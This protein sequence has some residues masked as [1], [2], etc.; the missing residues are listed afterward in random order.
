M[1]GL[2]PHTQKIIESV[3]RL[4]CI[5][6]YTLVGGTALSLQLG[7]RQSEDLDFMK[8]RTSKNEKIEVAW[9]QIEKELSQI[10]KIQHKDLLDIDH[11]EYLVSDVKLSFYACD[12]HSPVTHPIA[13]Q[14]N[15][16]LADII[17][18]G[19]M[20]IEVMLRRSNFRD[21]YDIYSIL[22]NNV[23]IQELITLATSYSGHKLKTKNIMAILTNSKRFIRDAHF[24]QLQPSY[25]ISPQEI[26][27]YIKFCL[28]NK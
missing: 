19:A 4:E 17:S 12:K 21:Y 28:S 15:I 24:E 2:A 7:T 8:W 13:Y 22:Q 10:G 1:K 27:E 20:K 11:V 23:P 6:P 5:K 9:Y 18:I 26:E 14:N 25:K 16:L 3:S